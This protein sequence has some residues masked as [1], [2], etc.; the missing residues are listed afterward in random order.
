MPPINAAARTRTS[1]PG[2]SVKTSD[3]I[4]VVNGAARIVPRALNAPA[5]AHTAV[6]V[7]RTLIPASRAAG[8]LA[9]AARMASP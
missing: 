5:S 7:R 1:R 6:D 8:G 9:A 3:E 4:D 2:P